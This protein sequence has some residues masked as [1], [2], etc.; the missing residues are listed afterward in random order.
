MRKVVMPNEELLPEI[1]GMLSEGGRVTF[2]T[3]GYSMLPFIV[4][5]RDSVILEK[6]STLAVGHIVLAEIAPHKFVLHRIINIEGEGITLMGDGNQLGV[7]T[8]RKENIHGY[9]VAILRKGKQV[10]CN[11]RREQRKARVWYRLLPVRRCLL[12][13]YRRVLPFL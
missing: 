3:K 7:E 12:A 8:C 9:A 2:K 6:P 10:D 4:G 11:S 5:D 13:V 1:A